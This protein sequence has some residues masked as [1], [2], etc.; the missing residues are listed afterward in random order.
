MPILGIFRGAVVVAF[1]PFALVA[2]VG[3]QSASAESGLTLRNIR[4]DVSPLRDS[5]GEPTASWVQRDLAQA[6]ASR[7]RHGAAPLVVRIDY[8]SFSS[9]THVDCGSSRDNISGVAT[10]G[11]VQ[12]PVRATTSY[13]PSPG[14]PTMFEQSNQ[15]RVSQLTRALAYWIAQDASF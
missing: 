6:L 10:I 11:G 5:V 9:G 3:S 8:L 12:T 15:D 13:Q 7:I 2:M 1:T 14:D 4:V